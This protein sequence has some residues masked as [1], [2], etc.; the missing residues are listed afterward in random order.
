M[1]KGAIGARMKQ[2]ELIRNLRRTL[3]VVETDCQLLDVPKIRNSDSY[4]HE[5]IKCEQ[6]ETVGSKIIYCIAREIISHDHVSSSMVKYRG[7][8]WCVVTM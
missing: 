1:G 8:C 4:R 6:G 3:F 2:K 5:P 7:V